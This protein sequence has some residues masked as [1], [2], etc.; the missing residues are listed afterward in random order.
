MASTIRFKSKHG[1][2]LVAPGT[3][4]PEPTALSATPPMLAAGVAGPSAGEVVGLAL[5]DEGLLLPQ[6][7]ATAEHAAART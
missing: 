1:G 5:R 6:N 4:D 2:G 3:E 7:V